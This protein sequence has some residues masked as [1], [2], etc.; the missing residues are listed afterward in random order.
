[1]KNFL[2]RF[3]LVTALVLIVLTAKVFGDATFS[4]WWK[5]VSSNMFGVTGARLVATNAIQTSAMM[6]NGSLG[7]GYY[8]LRVGTNG[9]AQWTNLN[10]QS[11]SSYISIIPDDLSFSFDFNKGDLVDSNDTAIFITTNTIFNYNF[12]TDCTGSITNSP[13]GYGFEVII[14]AGQTSARVVSSAATNDSKILA[15]L[16]DG[17]NFTHWR[18]DRS[19]GFFDVKIP[20]TLGQDAHFVVTILGTT[21]FPNSFPPFPPL[22]PNLLTDI[23]HWYDFEAN[24]DDLIGTA[25]FGNT[26]ITFTSER[27]GNGGV[28]DG[29]ADVAQLAGATLADIGPGAWSWEAWVNLTDLSGTTHATL[30]WFAPNDANARLDAYVSIADGLL[31]VRWGTG[32][33]IAQIDSPGPLPLAQWVHVAVTHNGTI[34][35]LYINGTDNATTTAASALALTSGSENFFIG[36]Q[37]PGNTR[38]WKGKIDELTFYDRALTPAEIASIFNSGSLGKERP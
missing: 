19:N 31:T 37:P 25:E 6:T 17:T 21:N 1:M 3:G 23:L 35:R 33:G 28:F 11:D 16:V 38:F 13:V 32:S 20:A 29:A 2:K 4:A 15:E 12:I 24:L 8:L 36:A 18:V 34:G 26:G 10:I 14:P 5:V 30:F 9:L 22:V 7:T 27:V